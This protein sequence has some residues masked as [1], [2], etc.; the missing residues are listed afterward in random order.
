MVG[1]EPLCVCTAPGASPASSSASEKPVGSFTPL[2]PAQSGH[3]STFRISS[4]KIS[5]RWTLASFCLQMPHNIIWLLLYRLARGF[6]QGVVALDEFP[7]YWARFAVADDPSVDLYDRHQLGPGTRQE[8]FIRVEQIVAS[9]VRLADA[10]ARVGGNT[11][12]DPASDAV[13]RASRKR[14]G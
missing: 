1:R 8:T 7:R 12:D 2:A 13:E 9:Q 14:R 10:Q 3:R 4:P 11:H 5:V 6:R